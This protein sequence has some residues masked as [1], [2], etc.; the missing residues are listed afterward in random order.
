[1]S[2]PGAGNPN[3]NRSS[4]DMKLEVAVLPVGDVYRAKR[5]YVDLGWR[6]DAD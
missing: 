2:K 4:L 5:F 6:L 1:M 3:A